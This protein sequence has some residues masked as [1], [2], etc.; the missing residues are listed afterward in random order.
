MKLKKLKGPLFLAALLLLTAT[1]VTVS[2][3]TAFDS[4]INGVA[5]G[6]NPIHIQEDFPDPTPTPGPGGTENYKKTVY[7]GNSLDGPPGFN[8]NCF[9]RVMLSYSN[10]DVGRAV[11]LLGLDTKNWVYNSGDGYYYYRYLLREQETTTPLITGFSIDPERVEDAYQDSLDRFEI[12][13]YAE[14]V[15]AQDY[16]DYISAWAAYT[17]G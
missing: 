14:S 11:T 13:V 5:V 2:Y 10:S 7:V 17:G 9:V 4:K 3:F 12:N 1:G 16:K 8:V 6:K 15:G